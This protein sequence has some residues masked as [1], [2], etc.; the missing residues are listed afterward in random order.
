MIQIIFFVAILS[1]CFFIYWNN[2]LLNRRINRSN[3]IAEKQDE[4]LEIL[5]KNQN[6]KDRS[7]AGKL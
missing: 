1:V 5:N 3:K 2:K 4:L 6:E 7:G